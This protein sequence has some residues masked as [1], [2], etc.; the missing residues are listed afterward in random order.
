MSSNVQ[1]WGQSN[2]TGGGQKKYLDVLRWIFFS[3]SGVKI[4]KRKKI[5]IPNYA[6]W[7]W[8]VCL[9]SRRN[10]RSGGH[11]YG[12]AGATESYKVRISV[13]A[14]TCRGGSE[15]KKRS[16]VRNLRLR[17]GVYLCF[18]SW[19]E[20]LILTL[21]GLKQ[22]FGGGAISEMSSSDTGPVIFL[23][24]HYPRWGAHFPRGKAQAV[25]CGRHNPKMPPRR[26][27]CWCCKFY[28]QPWRW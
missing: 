8:A 13:L 27:A 2:V 4:Q 16:S 11:V 25:I 18:L 15:D 7:I 26:R 5:F 21:G 22:Y 23:F 6:Q 17:L 14:L 10:Y 3:N 20:T 9:L 12:L 1:A 19:N 28:R 24:A